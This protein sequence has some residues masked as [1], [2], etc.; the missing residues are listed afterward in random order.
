MTVQVIDRVLIALVDFDLQERGIAFN[1]QYPAARKEIVIQFLSSAD[2]QD[3]IRGPV[4]LTDL[5][6]RHACRDSLR[7]IAWTVGPL[8]CESKS[9]AKTGQGAR[10]LPVIGIDRL[11]HRVIWVASGIFDVI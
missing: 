3:G 8:A 5:L 7:Q 9:F 6:H 2:V 11:S 4:E 1:H 10:R